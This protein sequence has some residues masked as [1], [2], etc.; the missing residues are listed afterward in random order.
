MLRLARFLFERA[1]ES[2]KQAW[3][4]VPGA[5]GGLDFLRARS[6]DELRPG[7]YGVLEP[8]Q[9]ARPVSAEELDLVALDAALTRL[10]ELAHLE[11][12]I[13]ASLD[14]GATIHG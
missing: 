3:L 1:L 5:E 13:V 10:A 7:R 2:G 9:G 8:P 12:E 14:G 11:G 6:W 4:P